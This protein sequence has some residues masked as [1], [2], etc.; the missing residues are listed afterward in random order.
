M[1]GLH[2]D[3]FTIIKIPALLFSES[4]SPNPYNDRIIL[5]I[6]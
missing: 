3:I 5:N 1:D 2:P 6:G 4:E